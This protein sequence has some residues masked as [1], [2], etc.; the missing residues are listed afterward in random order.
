MPSTNRRTFLQSAAAFTA[1]TLAAQ[2]LAASPNT[3]FGG[4]GNTILGANDRIRFGIIGPGGRGRGLMNTFL[5]NPE[6][7][8]PVVC[9]IDDGMIAEA[10]KVVESKRESTPDAVKDFRHLVEREDLDF[11]VV[12]TPDHWH[13]LPTIYSCQAGKDVYCEKPL[14]TSVGEGRAMLDHARKHERVVQMGTQWRSSSHFAEAVAF[15]HSGKL[16]KIRQVRCWAFLDWIGTPGRP[17]NGPVPEGVDYKMWLG[18]APT[19]PFNPARFHFTFR[20]FYD[21]AGGLMTDWG[22]HLLNI[23]MWAMKY[24]DPV[25]IAS[26]GGKFVLDDLMETPDT[27]QAVYQFENFSLIWEHQMK[28]GIGPHNRPH[29]I[30]FY[31]TEAT[32][33]LNSE[34]WE[35]IPEKE[36]PIPAETHTGAAGG[37]EEH[38][39]NFLDCLSSRERPVEDV[40]IGHKV[41]AIA[42]LGNLAYRTGETIHWDAEKER[43]IG[44]P[45]ASRWVT[46][47]YH[48][49]WKLPSV[50]KAPATGRPGFNPLFRS[51]T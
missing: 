40:E 33:V 42:H 36:K 39:R 48:N 28:T 16:G 9:D 24:P 43:V 15:V 49:G 38:V 31:G 7:D 25:R 11:V 1:S 47:P 41:S 3:F 35:V 20:W 6:V 22:V 29:G 19:V 23:A 14:A 37:Q 17:E 34:G 8:C 2:K 46:Q 51:R 32:L 18:P 13:A 45:K 4:I 44:S 50:A 12:A 27:Q 30:A 21:Y 10:I 26:T 5:D